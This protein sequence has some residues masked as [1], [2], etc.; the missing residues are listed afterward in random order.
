MNPFRRII[1]ANSCRCNHFLQLALTSSNPRIL[2]GVSNF[3]KTCLANPQ[4]APAL[5]QQ[6]GR[7]ILNVV[8]PRLQ[9]V[10]PKNML[11]ELGS[12]MQRLFCPDIDGMSD[13]AMDILRQVCLRISEFCSKSCVSAQYSFISHC[14]VVFS[15]LKIEFLQWSSA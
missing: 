3:L 1:Y 9:G 13:I 14:D 6:Y 7:Q 12:F 2:D 11:R 5:L 10:Y 8:L 15:G 4:V